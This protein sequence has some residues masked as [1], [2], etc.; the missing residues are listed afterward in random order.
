M[1]VF[2]FYFLLIVIGDC[3]AYYN[4]QW[5]PSFYLETHHE[6]FET[7]RM[8]HG[9]CVVSLNIQKSKHFNVE[10]PL[11][12]GSTPAGFCA[13]LLNNMEN[14]NLAIG[15][16]QGLTNMYDGSLNQNIRLFKV[17]NG[18]VQLIKK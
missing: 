13:I 6:K 18:N 15:I 9:S 3:L 14:L 5:M 2:T 7:L 17:K 4:N 11:I 1:L 12:N 8:Y 16:E 10:I